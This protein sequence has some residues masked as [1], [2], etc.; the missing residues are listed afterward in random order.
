MDAPVCDVCGEV[1]VAMLCRGK[2]PLTP[3][4]AAAINEVI[5]AAHKRMAHE[6]VD[7]ER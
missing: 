6:A 4:S 2:R 1:V 3:E 7:G 5:L